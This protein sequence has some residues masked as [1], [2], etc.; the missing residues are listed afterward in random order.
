MTKVSLC[1]LYAMELV[2]GRVEALQK[3][4]LGISRL[5]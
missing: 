1:I 4:K 2:G 5:Q 3:Q